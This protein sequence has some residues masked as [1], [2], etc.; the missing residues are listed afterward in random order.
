MGWFGSDPFTDTRLGTF[1]RTGGIWVTRAELPAMGQVELQLA[2]DRAAPSRESLACAHEVSALYAA[3]R[4]EIGRALYEHLEPYADAI[5]T[6]EM[7]ADGFDPSR[8]RGPEDTWPHVEASVVSIDPA[9]TEFPIEIQL[10]AA[11]DE[12]HTL[13]VRIRGGTLVEVCGSV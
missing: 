9:R 3:L 5:R 7:V 2:G 8:I 11:W 6:G 1:K 13:G 12:E 10:R 4:V